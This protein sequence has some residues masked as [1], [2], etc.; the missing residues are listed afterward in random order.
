LEEFESRIAPANLV[1]NGGFETG[2]FAGWTLSGN[3]ASYMNVLSGFQHSGTYAAHM[4]PVG[5]VGFISQTL[6]TTPGLTYILDYWLANEGGPPNDFSAQING[7]FLSHLVNVNSFGYTEYTIPFV[8][9][10]FGTSLNFAVRQDPSYFDLDDVSVTEAPIAPTFSTGNSVTVT[11]GN[12][13]NF[14]VQ[15]NGQPAPTLSTSGLPGWASFGTTFTGNNYA[16]GQLS[17]TPTVSGTY[18]FTITASNGV[19]PNAN[20]TFTVNVNPGPFSLSQSTVSTNPSVIAAGSTSTFKLQAKDQYGNNETSGGLNVGFSLSGGTSGGTI[21]PVTDNGN[22]TYTATFTGIT[23]G[24]TSTVNATINGSSVASTSSITVSPDPVSTTQSVVTAVPGT[25][26]AGSTSTFTL[27]AKD[28]FGNNET[29]GGLNVSF[30]LS[31]GTSNGTLSG[32]TDHNDGTYTV[33]FTGTTAGTTANV[34]ATI[35]GVGTVSS[36]PT[37][38]V[39]P[40]PFSTTVSTVTAGPAVITAGSTSTIT[41]VAK[42]AY[43]NQETSGGLNVGFTLGFGT[44]TG[45]IGPVTD[46]NNGTYTA[47]FTAAG[48]GGPGTP[49]TINATING[50]PVTAAPTITVIPGPFSLA[51]STVSVAPGSV[52]AGSTASITLQAKD[53]YGNNETSGGQNVGFGLGA[54]SSSGTISGVTDHGNG[55][56]TATFSGT[57]VGTPRTITATINGG[58]VASA[59]PTITVTP[60]PFSTAKSFITVGSSVI[61]NTTTTTVTLTPEDAFGNLLPTGIVNVQF[62]LGAG[63]SSGTFGPVTL[64]GNGTYSSVFTATTP[65]TATTVTATIN[66]NAVTSLLPTITVTPL[67]TFDVNGGL[68]SY[69]A[70]AGITNNIT[71]RQV[72]GTLYI[73]DL[74]QAIGLTAGAMAAGFTGNATNFIQGPAAAVAGGVSFNTVDQQDAIDVLTPGLTVP[75]SF[76]NP[77]FYDDLTIDDSGD[78]T[79]R[80][81]TLNANA[82]TG[83]PTTISYTASHLASLNIYGGSAGNTF[84]VADTGPVYFGTNVHTGVAANNVAVT[85]TEADPTASYALTITGQGGADTVTVGTPSAGGRTLAAI[86]GKVLVTNTGQ[87]TNLIVDDS[88]DTNPTQ[89]V[90]G[91]NGAVGFINGAPSPNLNALLGSSPSF[92]PFV[93]TGSEVDYNV[94]ALSGLTVKGGGG[95]NIFSITNTGVGFT[96]NLNSGLGQDI[97]DVQGTTGPLAIQGQDGRDRVSLDG[98]NTPITSFFAPGST[99]SAIKGTVS[100]ANANSLTDLVVNDDGDGVGRGFLLTGNQILSSIAATVTFVPSQLDSLTLE[101]GYGANLFTLNGLNSG[102][103]FTTTLDIGGSDSVNVSNMLG[104]VIVADPNNSAF[105]ST[106][107]APHVEHLIGRGPLGALP[108]VV[109]G[110][111]PSAQNVDSYTLDVATAG[112]LTLSVVPGLG[113]SLDSRLALRNTDSYL[114]FNGAPYGGGGLIFGSDD[115]NS[116]TANPTLTQYVL[117]G[118]YFVQVAAAQTSGPASFGS[119][120][121][122]ASLNVAPNPYAVVPQRAVVGTNPQD[123]DTADFN[124]DGVLDIATANH[125]SGDVSILLG[126]GDGTFQPALTFAV[127]PGDHPN[128][129][130]HLDVNGDG[131]PDIVTWDSTRNTVD[132]LLGIGDGRFVLATPTCLPA[133]PFMTNQLYAKLFND[134]SR[135][136]TLS[137]QP[138]RG[139]LGDFNRDGIPDVALL[140]PVS[141]S[142]GTFSNAVVV[143]D[144]IVTNVKALIDYPS[145][146]DL[147]GG[148]QLVGT[149]LT[150]NN[151]PFPLVASQNAPNPAVST[152]F[153]IDLNG[154]G[155]PDIV[156][157]KLDGT[158]EYRLGSAGQPGTFTPAKQVNDPLVNPVREVTVMNGPNGPEIAG[159]ALGSPNL[160]V[161]TPNVQPNHSISSW[162][163]SYQANLGVLA[164][165]VHITSGDLEGNG[166]PDLVI[167]GTLGELAIFHNL[168]NGSF[169]RLPDVKVAFGVSGVSVTKSGDIVY[170]DVAGGYAGVL[171]N[172]HRPPGSVGFNDEIDVA[173]GLPT[174]GFG[175]Q[176]SGVSQ[177][178]NNVLDSFLAGYGY[179]AQSFA[180]VVGV[181]TYPGDNP[182]NRELLPPLFFTYSQL[183]TGALTVA[184]FTN[185]GVQSAILLNRFANSFT[186]LLGKGASGDF[187]DPQAGDVY[188]TGLN[189]TAVAVGDFNHDGNLDVAILNAG[190]T[191]HPGS[192]WIFLGDGHGHFNL[193]AKYFAG[194]SPTGISAQDINGDGSIDLL[195]SNTFGDVQR[196]LGNGDGTF[197]EPESASAN[198]SLAVGNLQSGSADDFA[199]G[200]RMQNQVGLQLGSTTSVQAVPATAKQIE[201]PGPV[202]FTDLNGDG[203][204]DMIVVN[205]GGNDIIVYLGLGN[206]LYDLAHQFVFPVGTD[207]ASVTVAD[208]NGDGIPDMLVPNRG[209]NDVSIL[210]GQGSGTSWNMTVGER[211]SSG[212]LGPVAVALQDV[213]GPNGKPDGIPDLLVTNSLSNNV[214]LMPGVGNGFFNDQNPVAPSASPPVGNPSPI[215]IPI[216][217]GVAPGAV[218]AINTVNGPG[219]AVLDTGSNNLTEF[220]Q[221]TGGQFATVATIDTGGFNPVSLTTLDLNHDGITDLLVAN[222]NSLDQ[223][224]PDGTDTGNIGLLFGTDTGFNLEETFVD[225]NVP[226][227]SA[228]ALSAL[229]GDTIFYATTDGLEH[230]FPFCFGNCGSSPPPVVMAPVAGTSPGSFAPIFEQGSSLEPPVNAVVNDVP[231]LSALENNGRNMFTEDVTI[232]QS[233]SFAGSLALNTS[234]FLGPSE[235][236]KGDTGSAWQRILDTL[237][238][239]RETWVPTLREDAQAAVNAFSDA[240]QATLG[241]SRTIL[242]R[243][244]ENLGLTNLELPDL[245]WR[246]L[247]TNLFQ[248]GYGSVRTTFTAAALAEMG[249]RLYASF[250]EVVAPYLPAP[251]ALDQA[252]E[253]PA[254]LQGAQATVHGVGALLDGALAP[255]DSAD[256]H[257]RQTV[258][259]V[260][261][262]I[263]DAS[264]LLPRRQAAPPRE[265]APVLLA[266]DSLSGTLGTDDSL[267]VFPSV[268]LLLHDWRAEEDNSEAPRALC[269]AM[270]SALLLSMRDA[271]VIDERRQPMTVRSRPR[272][273]G[274]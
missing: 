129:I 159:I 189:P 126:N 204:P 216:P 56:Y 44:S 188:T 182:P 250:D 223:V 169:Q 40:G 79:G 183:E 101:G 104:S 149:F 12:P 176:E 215:L 103:G 171:V 84:T 125:D 144:G 266:L 66:G 98:F 180:S 256:A 213:T 184:D 24:S 82:I 90:M 174:N 27:Q 18:T 111:L 233:P 153:Y 10:P 209:S 166:L 50:S 112:Y 95:G 165:P 139:V 156:N 160:Y 170:T 186:F 6:A 258:E 141:G 243:L 91:V 108:T 192:V 145:L 210:L 83:L 123:I 76:Q 130:Y 52:A 230:A 167:G 143:V 272:A 114:I 99:L 118:Q 247:G 87:R 22:G 132:I 16:Q 232:E 227:P 13:V 115:Q 214:M 55:T 62:G 134:P 261:R 75:L 65:G 8:A 201:A 68:G 49:R 244:E 92:L 203:I 225:P 32:V 206:G 251:E 269:L 274:K 120:V 211:L 260:S 137:G 228:V 72:G 181:N 140:Q 15:A 133:G 7:N 2:S 59:L 257:W 14:T 67:S 69:L 262:S 31:G 200:D 194:T 4:G 36:Q 85:A 57:I 80:A 253:Q 255:L 259:T 53:Q 150:A 245:H 235:G 28:Q 239:I 89:S 1:T 151:Q 81:I 97:V 124:R 100:V 219:F 73:T 197:K 218:A 148:P 135:D 195:V 221:F 248:I 127:A 113:S 105:V 231:P 252:S 178:A 71:V 157:V 193:F 38:T 265:Q 63:T 154:D 212:G 58:N 142:P 96:T 147:V 241:E 155:V 42:D 3:V 242:V 249:D 246:E 152:P 191:T 116:G 102:G 190:D 172:Q 236:G 41:L 168:G 229:N 30:A 47:T 136:A 196:L 11:A 268:P 20:Q 26:Q 177:I 267:R 240:A 122:S 271:E 109:S 202:Q 131:R 88:G 61:P 138:T 224:N 51:Q 185:N 175:M 77:G 226:N 54:G 187:I 163:V 21:G 270:A 273:S 207:P 110:F 117:P 19:S 199:F 161:F 48:A 33:T 43:G 107:V 146:T 263:M 78:T 34:V 158:I 162:N 70:S 264:G 179:T 94:N 45:S 173:A 86:L 5:S 39:I 9:S 128:H 93:P 74:G 17:G 208:V 29:T 37:I 119:Y 64:N 46:N 254:L 23:S 237:E 217:V 222:N 234:V 106:A 205:S 198:I 35:A 60:G 238:E 25:I 220:S 164:L 121:L